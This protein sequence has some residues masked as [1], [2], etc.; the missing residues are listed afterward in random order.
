MKEET[1]DT[2]QHT[3]DLCGSL[4]TRLYPGSIPG[5]SECICFLCWLS[6]HVDP[7][8]ARLVRH[9]VQAMHEII[10]TDP[11]STRLGKR[12]AAEQRRKAEEEANAER[13]TGRAH[14]KE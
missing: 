7:E 1:P 11:P 8:S 10:D 6:H 12:L 2:P 4:V 5:A 14:A 9:I 13:R 3:C